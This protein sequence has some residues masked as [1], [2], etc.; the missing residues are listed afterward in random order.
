MWR[1]LRGKGRGGSRGTRYPAGSRLATA[2]RLHVPRSAVDV[3]IAA[4]SNV[5]AA[6]AMVRT[7]FVE[8]AARLLGVSRRTVYYRIREGRL[9]TVK[10]GGSC[11]VYIDSI[12]ALLREELAARHAP[13]PS[14]SANANGRA[15][16]A[17]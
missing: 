8:E 6:A 5:R 15:A 11:R 14:R 10:A 16:D 2:N 7:V 4:A 1:I 3:G 12:S 9:R 13:A 17:A